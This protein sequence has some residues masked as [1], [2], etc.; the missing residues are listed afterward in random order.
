MLP[1]LALYNKLLTGMSQDFHLSTTTRR[2]HALMVFQRRY[3]H[4][5]HDLCEEI[6]HLWPHWKIYN[7]QGSNGHYDALCNVFYRLECNCRP[8]ILDTW[9]PL[10]TR[11]RNVMADQDKAVRRFLDASPTKPVGR[12][13]GQHTNK[14]CRIHPD[15]KAHVIGVCTGCYARILKF[16]AHGIITDDTHQVLLDGLLKLPAVGGRCSNLLADAQ[17]LARKYKQEYA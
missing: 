2:I 8:E 11:T 4:L 14:Q 9:K 6:Q 12:P 10:V 1:N 5:L 16:R 7:N 17:D 13:R 3:G 15:K